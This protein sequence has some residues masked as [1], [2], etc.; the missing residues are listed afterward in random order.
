MSFYDLT[1]G[2]FSKDIGIDLGTANTL[3]YIKGEG[4]VLREPS[5][6]AIEKTTNRVVAI[7]E[8]AKQMIG[9]TPGDILA[10][11]PMR[12]GVIAD[13]DITS[14]MLQHFINRVS[15]NSKLIK[16][17]VIVG[18]PSGI[19]TV[20]RRAVIDAAMQTGARETYLIEE[21]MAAAIGVGLKI[22]EPHG[23]LIID[24]GGGTTEVAVVALGGM[25]ES[26]SIRVAGDDMDQAIISHCRRNY[27]LLIGERTA[28]QLKIDL[29][30]AYPLEQEKTQDVKGRDLVS[31]LPRNFTL[32]SVEIRDA[33]S[34]S[35]NTIVNAVS[36]TLEKTP[37]EI[38]SDI[39]EYGMV[40]TGGGSLLAGID[41]YISLETNM[42][43]SVANDPLSSVAYGTGAILEDM[44][45]YHNMLLS[46]RAL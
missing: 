21:P 2:R 25:V 37:P 20:E 14:T 41:K 42:K 39:M 11:R 29:G 16:P 34:E 9:R 31:G 33:L 3:V 22:F 12:D 36:M 10:I 5:V 27:N 18:I 23:S 28:E 40:M 17:N 4:I 30:S 19:T 45:K 15:K 26:R 46:S 43:V 7:G 13:F 1:V 44:P 24:I 32:S 35:V 8:E 38:A 6:V